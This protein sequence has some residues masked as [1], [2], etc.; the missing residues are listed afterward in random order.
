LTPVAVQF[1]E[2]NGAGGTSGS[3]D[4]GD[5]GPYCGERSPDGCFCDG[6]CAQLGDCCPDKAVVCDVGGP[7][8]ER[9]A[10]RRMAGTPGGSPSTGRSGRPTKRSDVRPA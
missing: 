7:L 3:C 8:D 9:G 2:G 4:G 10:H 5:E 6:L 1:R